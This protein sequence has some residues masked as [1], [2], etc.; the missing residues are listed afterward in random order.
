[1]CGRFVKKSTKEELRARF[2]FQNIPSQDNLFDARYNIAPSQEHPIIV[3]SE[4]KRLVAGMKWGLVPYW[5]KDPKI[6]YKMINARAEGIHEKPSF[7]TPL[8]KR[9]CLVPAD[10]FYE[11]HKADSKTKI[12]Y[13]FR[14][15]S[16]QP[17]AFAGLWDVWENDGKKLRTFTII[18]TEPNE[19]M[20]PI[21]NRMPVILA[22]KD[23]AKWLDPELTG[24]KDLLPLLQSYPS[25]EMECFRVSTIVN[26]PKNDVPEC[27]FP[28]T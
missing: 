19:L 21:H 22:E 26:S 2:G 18:T 6:G 14:L 4:D 20:E 3:V 13:Y 1:M 24:V 5:S 15:K 9:R 12:P 17:F 16:E 28:A 7:K 25:D 23:E 11:W 8:R 10:G 27:L